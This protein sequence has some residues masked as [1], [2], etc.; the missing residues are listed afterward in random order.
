MGWQCVPQIK[1]LVHGDGM[2]KNGQG[3]AKHRANAAAIIHEAFLIADRTD[4]HPIPYRKSASETYDRDRTKNNKYTNDLKTADAVLAALEEEADTQRVEVAVTDKE[5]GETV[6]RKRALPST[7]VFGAAVIFN[8]PSEVSKDWT[9][10]QYEKFFRDCEDSLAQIPFGK[11]DPKTGE[12]KGPSYYLFR[13]D[14]I[15]AGV[16]HWDEGQPMDPPIYTGH[17]H[18]IYKPEGQDGKYYGKLIDSYN[19]SIM[20]NR[21]FAGLMRERGW[22]IDD[23]DCTDWVE[24]EADKTYK[25]KRKAKIKKSG[26]SVNK[27]RA[28]KTLEDAE[29]KL[30]EAQ[31]ALD[32]AAA[33]KQA[34]AQR[35]EIDADS[36]RGQARAEADAMLA[37]AAEDAR[38]SIAQAQAEAKATRMAA[39]DAAEKAGHERMQAEA[40]RDKARWEAADAAAARKAAEAGR[41]A[42]QQEAEDAR[43]QRMA[44]QMAVKLLDNMRT[45]AL[46]EI[47]ELERDRDKAL[48][49]RDAARQE[50][51]EARKELYEARMDCDAAR[52]EA[53]DLRREAVA[54]AELAGREAARA[55]QAKIEADAREAWKNWQDSKKKHAEATAA[56][57]KEDAK[58]EAAEIIAAAQGEYAFL[59]KWL[60]DPHQRYKTGESFLEVARAAH[61]REIRK[62]RVSAIPSKVQDAGKNRQ[63]GTGRT[64]PGT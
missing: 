2:R 63:T 64:G 35:A 7:T 40:D 52:K 6:I 13:R 43:Q 16:E 46:D 10:D 36:I 29:T 49:D 30:D 39:R 34:V 41:D 5:T 42:A 44:A 31:A 24:F 61:T 23:P 20:V 57:I 11:V 28:D 58:A 8:P 18:R 1:G 59:L 19:L 14:N 62:Q 56:K 53:D 32:Q 26:K 22:D 60:A 15:V 38:A 3:E 4:G 33:L 9:P 47:G 51:G 54:K 27:Y 45:A 21:R 25:A 55:T 37:D 50:A 12:I 17:V 48:K